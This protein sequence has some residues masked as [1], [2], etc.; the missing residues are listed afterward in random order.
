MAARPGSRQHAAAAGSPEGMELRPVGPAALSNHA[1]M[2]VM[3]R[4]EATRFQ[5]SQS[6]IDVAQITA[7]VA[8]MSTADLNIFGASI[9]LAR[10]LRLSP[11][12]EA[13][14]LLQMVA[15]TRCGRAHATGSR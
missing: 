7:A 10:L 14:A 8:A 6:A 12:P 9:D 1:V 15:G 3:A 4:L 5:R 11:A 13:A 2:R